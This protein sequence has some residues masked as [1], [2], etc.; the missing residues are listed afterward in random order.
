MRPLRSAIATLAGASLLLGGCA[1]SPAAEGASERLKVVTTTGILADIAANVGGDH[2]EVVSLVPEGGDPHSYE[3]SLR[4]IRDIVY[5]D[6]AFTNYLMLE[7]QRL[8]TT[9]DANLPAD[10]ANISLAEEAVKYAANLIPLVEDASLDTVWFGFRA[11]GGAEI[12]LDRSAVVDIAATHLD[13]PGDLH[14][15]LTGSFGDVEQYFDSTDGMRGDV[16]DTAT[17][18]ADAHTH[19]SWAFTQPGIYRLEVRADLRPDATARP[20]E[21]ARGEVVFA[22]GVDPYTVPGRPDPIVLDSGHA[23]LTVDLASGALEV[24]HDRDPGHRGEIAGR[25]VLPLDRVVVAVPNTARH[26]IPGEPGYRFLGR[27]GDP[28]YQLAQAVLGK[29]VHGEIDPHLWHDVANVKAYA[30]IMRDTFIAHDPAHAADYTRSTAAYLAA[31]DALDDELRAT[32]DE[33]PK[34]RRTL[35]TTHDSFAYLA[36]AYDLQVAGFITPNPAIEPSLAE[37][38]RLTETIRNLEVPAVFLEPNLA[39]QSSTLAEVAAEEGVRVCPILGDAFTP[40][41][42]S[43]IELMR[44]NAASLRDCLGTASSPAPTERTA[45]P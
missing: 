37:R 28:I 41:I 35:I 27:A 17:L 9:L 11:E 18:P 12:G 24:Q 13:G 42:H 43:Y 4:N 19:L 16:E 33:I 7:E 26:E 31:L 40:Q 2:V 30:Q 21:V 36:A 14:A 8:I 45:E 1:A 29:H 6:V 44:F 34:P 22:V 10:A 25:D 20:E 32:I 39:Q 15:Y 3:P 23:D 38:R 5:A